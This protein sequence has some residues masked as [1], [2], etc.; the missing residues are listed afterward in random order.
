MAK[1]QPPKLKVMHVANIKI[2]KSK[3]IQYASIHN[4]VTKE[5]KRKHK[6]ETY[7]IYIYFI[8]EK[9]IVEINESTYFKI[10]MFKD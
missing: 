4:H 6:K 8:Y 2:R 5:E 3:R 9:K 1:W 10:I 7:E